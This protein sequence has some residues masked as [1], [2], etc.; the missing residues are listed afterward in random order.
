M[1]ATSASQERA[2]RV[3]PGP[4]ARW[5][6]TR[7][8]DG[9]APK[10]AIVDAALATL[11]ALVFAAVWRATGGPRAGFERLV[12]MLGTGLRWSVALPIAWGALGAIE[13]DR[14]AGLLDLAQRRGVPARRW[15]VGRAF[16]AGL[17]VSICVGVPMVVTSLVLAAFGGGVEG[18]LARLSLLLPSIV[19]ALSS[20][21]VFGLGA[22]VVGALVRSRPLAAA[23]FVG[24]ATLG[25]L[26]DLL[27]PGL[28][29][30]TAHQL[31]SPFLALEDLQ[32]AVFD[33]AGAA[34]RGIAAAVA[35]A[36]VLT[37]GLRT[38]ELAF[39]QER[40]G[41]RLERE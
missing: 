37:L 30:A 21:A 22:V 28:A 26:I 10:L 15:I 2:G 14:R 27:V 19:V 13:A 17:L 39:D 25:V 12:P 29:G 6:A 7:A 4:T 35:I 24:A 11:V 1:R 9:A 40:E 18:A 31:L 36:V 38:G 33:V 3:A 8:L 41:A 23:F 16:G 5:F 34:P 20:G 32:A